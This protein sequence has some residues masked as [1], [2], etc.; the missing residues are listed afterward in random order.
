MKGLE[1]LG[2][3]SYEFNFG[4]KVASLSSGVNLCQFLL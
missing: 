1:G 3:L 2:R 4:F